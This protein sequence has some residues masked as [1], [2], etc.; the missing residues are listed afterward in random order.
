MTKPNSPEWNSL[1]Q[2]S[3]WRWNITN[4]TLPTHMSTS[5]TMLVATLKEKNPSVYLSI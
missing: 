1:R 4:R 5:P 2:Y 3:R